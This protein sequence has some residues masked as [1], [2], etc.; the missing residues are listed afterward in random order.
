MVGL[1]D[2][3][4]KVFT[5]WSETSNRSVLGNVQEI[6]DQL[7]WNNRYVK[8]D[9]KCVFYKTLFETGAIRIRDLFLD[10]NTLKPFQY[11][12]DKGVKA[13]LFLEWMAVFDAIPKKLRGLIRNS[14]FN[15]AHRI[16]STEL[17]L[18][19]GDEKIALQTLKTKSIYNFFVKKIALPPTNKERLTSQFQIQ[20]EQEW[21]N[22]YCLPSLTNA[23]R[24]TQEFRYRSLNNYLN[25]KDRL[26]KFGISEDDSCSFCNKV[27]ETLEHLFITCIYVQ[28]FWKNLLEWYRQFSSE[29]IT[30]DLRTIVLGWR[31]ADPPILDNF[32]L[33]SAKSYIFR[34]KVCCKLPRVR[35]YK[36]ILVSCFLVGRLCYLKYK[37]N[38]SFLDKWS[39]L[40]NLLSQSTN[41]QTVHHA[42]SAYSM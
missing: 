33:L 28:T 5:V 38:K 21:K 2:Y 29:V 11:W 16:H 19:I 13:S 42:L 30:I 12:V 26:C 36:E 34:C 17:K 20:D 31:T 41:Q 23:N 18:I 10:N 39:T 22:I 8:V 15:D 25:T 6:K 24:R 32:I 40:R 4:K 35:E 3:Y 7:I 9:K 27:P 14:N 1:P 37:K